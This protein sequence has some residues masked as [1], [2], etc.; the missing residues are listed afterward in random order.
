MSL[1]LGSKMVFA[2]HFPAGMIPAGLAY[3]DVPFS[4]PGKRAGLIILNDKPINAEPPPALLD[5]AL[6][7]NDLFFVRYNGIPSENI[8]VANWTLTIEGE[9]VESRWALRL[10]GEASQDRKSRYFSIS[11]LLKGVHRFAQVKYFRVAAKLRRYDTGA[12]RRAVAARTVNHYG[13]IRRDLVSP[14]R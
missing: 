7:P 8:D 1:A 3:S 2:G 9:S 12:Y 14:V 4:I 6:T 5:D 13:L 11:S 10:L